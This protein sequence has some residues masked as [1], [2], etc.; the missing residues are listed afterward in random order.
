MQAY[1]WFTRL[2]KWTAITTMGMSLAVI[3]NCNLGEVTATTTLD[4]RDVV[5]SLLKGA[6]LTPIETA[7]NEGVEYVFDKIDDSDDD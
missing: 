3:G 1:A 6:L 4:G 5:T 7:I 2:R